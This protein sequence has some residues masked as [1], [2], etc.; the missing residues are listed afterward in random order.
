VEEGLLL[1]LSIITLTIVLSV[2]I[3][4]ISGVQK[5]LDLSI[6]NGTAIT[7]GLQNTLNQILQYFRVG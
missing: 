2:I 5:T 1:G 4:L 3:G 6:F 7:Q